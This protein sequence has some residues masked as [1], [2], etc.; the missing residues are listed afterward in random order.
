MALFSRL[1]F[2]AVSSGR[3][4]HAWRSLALVTLAV[5]GLASAAA[6]AAKGAG[7]GKLPYVYFSVG[8]PGALT[9][10]TP[11]IGSDPQKKPSFLLMGGGPDVDE[12]FRLM[13]RKAGATATT[14]GRFLVIRATG[15]DAYNSYI[16][17]AS[18]PVWP[19]YV[20]GK[21]LHLSSVETLIIPSRTAAAHPDVSTIIRRAD[22]LFI[23]GGDQADYLN[24]WKG[25]NA[26]L[27]IQSLMAR[28][29]PIGGT[30]AGLAVLGQ[31]DFAALN[32]TVQS[33]QA[34]GDPFNRY[35]TLDPASLSLSAGFIA[36]AAL[37]HT[38]LDSHL[39]TRDRLGRLMVFVA[40]MVQQNGDRGGC[41]GGVLP[42]G[43]QGARGIGL[44]VETALWIEVDAQGKTTAKRV[45]NDAS[46]STYP[47]DPEPTP[48]AVYFVRPL[49]D[50]STCAA[51][52]P[53]TMPR[54]E[55][56]RLADSAVSFDLSSWLLNYGDQYSTGAATYN[57]DINGGVINWGAKPFAY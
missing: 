52:K 44:G 39:D 48:S 57:A 27:A 3:S 40:R 1:L 26:D 45:T 50:P 31:I 8:E 15:T 24:Y 5:L 13:V 23:A 14:G 54:V 9:D 18:G 32:G 35:M 20:G 37:Q 12:G 30:S 28:N 46:N 36:P 7:G 34:L 22:M 33:P 17:D 43:A 25:T 47:P 16:Y 10:S 38:V 6:M 11:K 41:S 21:D 4:L 49:G 56:Y 29:V 2:G 19:S 42:S 53:L 51:K 55:V